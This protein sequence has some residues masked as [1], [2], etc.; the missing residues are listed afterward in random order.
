MRLRPLAVHVAAGGVV[1]AVSPVRGLA[2][3][4]RA[5]RAQASHRTAPPRPVTCEQLAWQLQ[6]ACRD[7]PSAMFFP[8]RKY[9]HNTAPAKAV[10][11][12]CTVSAECLQYAI[13]YNERG[14]WGGTSDEDR[15]RMRRGRRMS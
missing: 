2:V 9:P 12:G 4:A 10:C 14:V 13:D 15:K 5:G 3:S 1:A 11:R 6:A 8:E 7:I